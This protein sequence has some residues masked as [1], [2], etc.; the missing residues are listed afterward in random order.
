M[1]I[2]TG[3]VL[4]KV[5]SGQQVFSGLPK[6]PMALFLVENCNGSSQLRRKAACC[7]TNSRRA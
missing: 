1:H 5:R 6:M 2:C 7:T 3:D 4:V